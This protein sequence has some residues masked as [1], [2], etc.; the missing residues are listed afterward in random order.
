MW[1]NKVGTFGIGTASVWFGRLAAGVGRM[2]LSIMQGHH[3]WQFIYA[4]DLRFT[5]HGSFLYL[6]L[7]LFLLCWE[8]A[9][10]PFSWKKTRGGLEQEWIGFWVSC[11]TFQI[12][13]SEARTQWVIKWLD[14]VIAAPGILIR[15]LQEGLGRIGFLAGVLEWTK[16]FLAPCYAW[17]S[18]VPG[19][20]FLPLPHIIKLTFEW[21]RD[22]LEDGNRMTD[23]RAREVDVGEVFRADTKGEEGFICIGG[24]EC[25]GG[26]P[27]NQARWFSIKILPSQAPWLFDKGHA[28]KTI[29]AGELLA[30]LVSVQAFMSDPFE[31]RGVMGLTG[32]TDNQENSFVLKK[33]LSSKYPLALILMQL[34]VLLSERKLWLDL[35][36]RPRESNVE[37]DDL[38]NEDF[39]KFSPWLRVDLK[40]SDLRLEV[41]SKYADS[42]RALMIDKAKRKAEDPEGQARRKK[43]FR[44]KEKV[45]SAW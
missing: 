13:A 41:V 29:A 37:A 4:D 27:P 33:M 34:S 8:V 3:C 7:L 31:A 40:F 39:S 22:R 18:S 36:W 43:E 12:G 20:A 17:S 19:G 28:S 23:C 15:G 6:N 44:S 35:E 42:Y 25:R 16:P 11:S 24:W 10:A 5:T 2:V 1:L 9:G 30:T 38:T 32:V 26:T 21:I 14:E 45:L